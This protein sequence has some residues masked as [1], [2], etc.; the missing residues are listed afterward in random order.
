MMNHLDLRRRN[1][2]FFTGKGLDIG[3]FDKPFIT[4]PKAL[5]LIVETVDRWSPEDLKRLFPEIKD[6]AVA[7]P[8]YVLDVSAKGLAFSPNE[9]YDFVICSHVIEHVANPFWLIHECYRVLKD[10]GV[11]YLSVPDCRYS[12]DEGRALTSYEYLLNLYEN[13]ITEIPDERVLD[14]LRGP[15]IYTGWVKKAFEDHAITR[16]ILDNERLRS[17]HVH[18]W[19]S[20]LFMGQFARF[21][22]YAGFCLKLLDLFVWENNLYEGVIV[23]RKIASPSASKLNNSIAHLLERR[24]KQGQDICDWIFNLATKW[25]IF[26]NRFVSKG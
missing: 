13:G 6:S 24:T 12:D 16:E 3:P 5:G 22:Q 9:H 25:Y 21:S 14:Y 4:D 10:K 8:T 11:L 7:S 19:D 1:Q 18:V 2:I 15:R 26:S 20:Q 23:V 17:F